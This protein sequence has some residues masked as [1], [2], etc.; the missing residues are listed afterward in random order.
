LTESDQ[1]EERALGTHKMSLNREGTGKSSLDDHPERREH[2]DEDM[3][4]LRGGGNPATHR[5]LVVLP[6]GGN[7]ETMNAPS[8]LKG[9]TV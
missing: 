9:E 2:E 3:E 6:G 8:A 1:T 7:K 5:M 4:T